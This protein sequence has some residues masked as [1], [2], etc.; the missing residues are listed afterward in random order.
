[1]CCLAALSRRAQDVA[2]RCSKLMLQTAP[3]LLL[4]PPTAGD[5]ARIEGQPIRYDFNMG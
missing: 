3:V 4:F 1:M 2:D 5:N